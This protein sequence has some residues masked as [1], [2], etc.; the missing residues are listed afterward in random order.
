MIDALFLIEREL[1]DPDGLAG[2]AKALALELRR[3][4][5]AVESRPL[6]EQLKAWAEQQTALPRSAL[7]EALG[8]LLGNWN[9]LTA[10][11]ADPLIPLTNNRT[12]RAL[13]GVVLGRKNHYGSR[14]VRGTQVAAIMYSLIETCILCGVDPEVNLPRSGGHPR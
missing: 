2:E 11:L 12:E 8:Y 5:R 14:S 7:A 9:G 13:R 6:T 3:Q 10:F 1:T 4:R